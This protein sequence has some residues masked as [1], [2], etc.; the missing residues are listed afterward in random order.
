MIIK[1]NDILYMVRVAY[2][3]AICLAF[4]SI[5]FVVPVAYLLLFPT[6][7]A[8][9][10]LQL[11]LVS[12][13]MALVSAGML[14]GISFF[15]FGI[16]VGLWSVV[17]V[18]TGCALGVAWRFGSSWFIRAFITTIAA[19]ASLVGVLISLSWITGISL[20]E[21]DTVVKGLSPYRELP[22][23]FLFGVSVLIIGLLIWLVSDQLV[24]RVL[25]QLGEMQ[26]HKTKS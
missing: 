2:L 8:I 25:G 1:R 12:V 23:P 20:S 16:D 17:Y 19:A 5:Q 10:A 15:V 11:F 24:S 9:V 21:V 6:V 7:P 26:E 14:I 18:I 13:S 3:N 4:L 22:L